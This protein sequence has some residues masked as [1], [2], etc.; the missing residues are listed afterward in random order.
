MQSHDPSYADVIPTWSGF[1]SGVE[2]RFLSV[3]E[4]VR[5]SIQDE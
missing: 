1:Y 2:A 4:V 3:V 5:S